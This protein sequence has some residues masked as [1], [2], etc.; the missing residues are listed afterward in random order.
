MAFLIIGDVR[1]FDFA[2][3]SI[4]KY[5]LAHDYIDVGLCYVDR[6]DN[7]VDPRTVWRNRVIFT[8]GCSP[9]RTPR[10]STAHGRRMAGAC[11]TA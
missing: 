9:R 6:P 8:H 11:A 10:R 3:P 4:E 7:R 5:V 2:M 1:S